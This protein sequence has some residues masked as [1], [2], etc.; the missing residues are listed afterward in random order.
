MKISKRSKPHRRAR[1]KP[2]KGPAL[3]KGNPVRN[4]VS[5]LDPDYLVRYMRIRFSH[6][7]I[8]RRN[9]RICIE[10]PAVMRMAD[11]STANIVLEFLSCVRFACSTKGIPWWFDIV[12]LQ[13][14]SPMCALLLSSEFHRWQLVTGNKLQLL[15]ADQW[16]PRIRTLFYEL[17]MFN[18]VLVENA[19]KL[20]PQESIEKYIKLRS[21]QAVK[22]EDAIGNI[23]T[24]VH[25]VALVMSQNFQM[26]GGIEEAVTNVTQWAYGDETQ[27]SPKLSNRW[28][29]CASYNSETKRTTLMVYDHGIGITGT[30][31]TSG[32]LEEIKNFIKGFDISLW[33]DAD[34]IEAAMNT[35]RSASGHK[36]RGKGLKWMRDLLQHFESG[37]LLILSGNGEYRIDHQGKSQKRLF[38]TPLGG[39][40]IAWEVYGTNVTED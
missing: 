17:G 15:D 6:L 22:M 29:F 18:L 12:P 10:C 27:D 34:I 28:W 21:G 19:Y 37:T 16:H 11:K 20:A 33:S 36:H 7:K 26:Y 40:L 35:P 24:Q 1:F 31:P 38:D 25:K 39:T 2:N 13:D 9:N 32:R 3:R 23:S 14:I 30:L 4:D 8:N 5:Q